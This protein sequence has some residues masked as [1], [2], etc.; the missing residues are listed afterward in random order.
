MSPEQRRRMGAHSRRI[1]G[2]YSYDRII[3]GLREVG[4]RRFPS[5]SAALTKAP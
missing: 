3:E 2:R 5:S 4:R 1:I